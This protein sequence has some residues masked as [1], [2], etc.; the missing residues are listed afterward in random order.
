MK[1]GQVFSEPFIFIFAIIVA[2]LVLAWGFKII[3][4]LKE[5]AQIVDLSD[6]ITSLRNDIRTYYSLST[7]SSKK[8]EYKLPP[9]IKCFCFKDITSNN[10]PLLSGN[11]PDVCDPDNTLYQIMDDSQQKYHLFITPQ[12]AYQLT[13]NFNLAPNQIQIFKP[14]TNPLC[15]QIKNNFFKAIIE[16]KGQY[17]EIRPA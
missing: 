13:L 16:N 6:T 7:T 15:I 14:S 10:I 8:I 1:K 12:D 5:K 17:V 3:V 11:I 2:A 9:K 4:D